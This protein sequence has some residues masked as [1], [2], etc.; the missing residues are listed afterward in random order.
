MRLLNISIVKIDL[1][2][3]AKTQKENA[4]EEAFYILI[5]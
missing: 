3:A 4:S 1:N 5:R 2:V